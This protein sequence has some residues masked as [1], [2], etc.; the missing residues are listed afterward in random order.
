MLNIILGSYGRDKYMKLFGNKFV[1]Y[2]DGLF[3]DEFTEAWFQDPFVREVLEKIDHIDQII[4]TALH[5]K[6]TGHTHSPRELSTGCKTVILMYK[7]PEHIFQAR[8]GDNCIELV[9]KLASTRDVT[10][11]SG[12]MHTIQFKYIDEVHYI[13]LGITC[14]SNSEIIEKVFPLFYEYDHIE[15]DETEED[16]RDLKEID[17]DLYAFLYEGGED[18]W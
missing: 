15:M 3:D 7:F 17:P 6:I 18:L 8:F 10:V 1:D 12:Y 13:N 9:E 4:G 11:V 5:N 14:K 2:N 16:D